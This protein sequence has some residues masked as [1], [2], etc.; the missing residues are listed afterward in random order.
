MVGEEDE[1]EGTSVI[2]L[3]RGW[4]IRVDRVDRPLVLLD[5]V[6]V[7]GCLHRWFNKDDIC[8]W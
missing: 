1:N 7:G 4:S 2:E 8:A 6:E 3:K 5:F